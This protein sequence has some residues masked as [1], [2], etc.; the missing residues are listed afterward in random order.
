MRSSMPAGAPAL[1]RYALYKAGTSTILTWLL[2]TSAACGYGDPKNPPKSPVP[3]SRMLRCAKTVSTKQPAIHIPGNIIDLTL[4]VIRGRELYVEM[5]AS[6]GDEDESHQH[7]IDALDEIAVLLREA[8]KRYK[9][10]NPIP[11]GKRNFSGESGVST[12]SAPPSD[13]DN[14]AN[15]FTKLSVEE[16]SVKPFSTPEKRSTNKN[17]PKP[18]ILLATSPEEERKMALVCYL[19]DMAESR[20]Y[21]RDLWKAYVAGELSLDAVGTTTELAFGCMRRAE[22]DLDRVFKTLGGDDKMAQYSELALAYNDLFG[23]EHSDSTRRRAELLCTC[24]L[25][26]AK[27][28]VDGCEAACDPCG[29]RKYTPDKVAL[30]ICKSHLFGERLLSIIPDFIQTS[31]PL[32]EFTSEFHTHNGV[33]ELRIFT[34]MI[35]QSYTE[36]YDIIGDP[37]LIVWKALE[38]THNRFTKSI[39][40]CFYVRD[41]VR[42]P[43]PFSTLWR[44]EQKVAETTAFLEALRVSDTAPKSY[45]NSQ[46]RMFKVLPVAAIELHIKYLKW[47]MS[48]TASVVANDGWNMIAMSYLYRASHHYGMMSEKWEDL[49][50]LIKYQSRNRPYVIEV[51]AHADH[52]AFSRYH[53][54]AWGVPKDAGDTKLMGKA[55]QNMR[56]IESFLDFPARMEL[57]SQSQDRLGC[58]RGEMAKVVLRKMASDKFFGKGYKNFVKQEEKR[59]TNIELL[60]TFK[61]SFIADETEYN[62]DLLGF[63]SDVAEL[64]QAMH[65]FLYPRLMHE[66]MDPAEILDAHVVR[67][68]LEEAAYCKKNGLPMNKPQIALAAKMMEKHVRARGSY[69]LKATMGLSSGTLLEENKPKIVLPARQEN[70]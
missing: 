44:F 16:P 60:E 45:L 4:S 24:A 36:I 28:T 15:M 6:S 70:V 1:N 56:R 52:D 41:R 55:V 11:S 5:Y 25:I 9:A 53:R 63:W 49:E 8:R 54:M 2:A 43:F 19:E 58:E 67:P 21:I 47:G 27:T 35:V 26:L 46:A 32:D 62:I 13:H 57:E 37:T 59:F 65:K 14:A 34:V 33:F 64:M 22:E 40:R 31:N 50:W 10:E 68:L 38:D 17:S 39:D 23:T 30:K 29:R 51:P 48:V 12:D 61:E 66:E 7:F 42:N 69:Y 20:K 18:C 3:V